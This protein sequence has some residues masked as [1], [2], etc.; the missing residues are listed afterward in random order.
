MGPVVAVMRY[1]LKSAQGE[2]LQ[3]VEV[4]AGGLHADRA[5]AC[6]DLTDG[7][8]GSAKHPGRWGRLLELTARVREPGD[9]VIEVAG[10]EV[11]AGTEQAEAALRAHLGREVALTCEVPEHAR[12]HRRLPDDPALV[13]E[14][15]VAG[16]GE[17]TVT[18][19]K[20][21]LPGGRF[22]DY[23]AVHLLTTGQLAGVARQLGR[24]AVDV[25]P[26]RPNLVLDAPDDPEVGQE[27]QLGDVVLRVVLRTPR[28]IVPGLVVDDGQSV[29]RALLGALARHHRAAVADLG[30]AACFGVYA[31]VLQPG[32]V[33]VGQEVR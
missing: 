4:E 1:P 3:S 13:P 24:A 8:V 29:D 28:C 17:E 26:F 11:V 27:L 30:R 6:R 9:V 14:W 15:M 2:R 22:V 19:I 25:T 32:R 12:L 33:K 31:Q 23:A 10:R 16:A 5:W 21:A 7:T 18:D 20:G